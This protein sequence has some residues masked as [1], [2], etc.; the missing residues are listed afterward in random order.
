[1][2]AH[3]VDWR[4][5]I[6]RLVVRPAVRVDRDVSLAEA[7]RLMTER[8][9]SALLVDP[10]AW[11]ILTERDLVRAMA[12]G[13]AP[14][15][16]VAVVAT[17]RPFAVPPET[18]IIEAVATMLNEEVRHLVVPVGGELGVVSLRELVATLLQAADTHLW[19]ASLRVLIGPT[20]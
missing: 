4:S 3:V 9:V 1:M 5:P 10:D 18:P 16:P 8:G 12:A 15:E 6:G 20:R 2:S 13:V 11:A 19:L 17:P 14:D 7:A